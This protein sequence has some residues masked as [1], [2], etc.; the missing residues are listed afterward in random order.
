[1]TTTNVIEFLRTVAARPD[2]LDSLKTRSKDDVI[3]AAAGFGYPFSE[4]DFDSIIWD[5]E[6]KLAGK[7][8][9]QFDPQF[10]LWQTMWGKYYLEYLVLDLVPSFVETGLI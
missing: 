1:M 10:S 3:D 5:L 7:R 2:V 6:A 4:A 9:E 8:G